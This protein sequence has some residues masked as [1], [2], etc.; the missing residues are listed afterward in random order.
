V[1]SRELARNPW[2]QALVAELTGRNRG[3]LPGEELWQNKKAINIHH[4]RAYVATAERRGEIQRVT[5]VVERKHSAYVVVIR[6]K[7][8][9]KR[10]PWYAAGTGIALGWLLTLSIWLWSYRGQVAAITLAAALAWFLITR[11][12]HRGACAGLH[13]PGC[14]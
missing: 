13:C 6:L 7:R 3:L 2:T 5:N 11:L 12:R 10:W 9:A 8:P 4:F 14:R 1:V